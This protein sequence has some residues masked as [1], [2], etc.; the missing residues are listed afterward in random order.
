MC[1]FVL[2]HYK[3]NAIL[4]TPISGMDNVSIFKAY[5]KQFDALTAKGLKPKKN[6]MD[7]QATKH[8]KKFLTEQQCKMQLVEPHNH[9]MNAAKCAIQTYKDA[10]IAALATTDKDFPI[11]LWDKLAPQVQ[12]TLNLLRASRVNPA[13]SAYK[14]LNGPYDWN[15]YP[16]A[17]LACKAV[18]YKDGDTRGSWASQ[19]VDGWYLGPFQDHC[20][21]DLYY[22]PKTQAYWISG[23]TKLFPQHCQLPNLT[24]HQHLR[25]LTDELAENTAVAGI[26][27]KGRRLIKLL[28]SKINTILTP[29]DANATQLAKQRV[30]EEQQRVIDETPMLTIPHITNAPPIMQ[31]SEV[32]NK[33]IIMGHQISPCHVP[34]VRS[35]FIL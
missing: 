26:T 16:L 34:V 32:Q 12:D 17:P 30:R 25:A 3:S 33:M 27:P 35:F 22:I 8:I 9:Q 28:Q 1:F 14:I 11:Q 31:A 13:I 10:F 15:R 6:I 23:S 18:V 7:N 21:C 24:A 2:C 29:P 20:R 19:G 4:V 5:K